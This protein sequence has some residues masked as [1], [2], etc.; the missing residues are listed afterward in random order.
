VRPIRLAFLGTPAAAV[1]AL[2]A[3]THVAEVVLVVTQPDRPRGRSNR[4]QPSPVKQ[5]ALQLGLKVAQPGRSAELD[6]ALQGVAPLDVGVL[7]AF[8]QL[9]RPEALSVPRRG[10]LNGHLSLLPRWRGAAP[11]QRA[12]LAG[13]VRT[14]VSVM[15]LEP[16]LDTGPVVSSW[17]TV[18]GADED[19]G[20]LTARLAVGAA[21]ML[22]EI[23]PQWTSGTVAAVPQPDSGITYAAKIE[24]RD[25]TIDWA[26]P[27][28]ECARRVRAMSPRPGAATSLGGAPFRVL[29]ATV[30]TG[31][32][33]PG[34]AERAGD[35]V[36]V[37]CGEG[38]LRLDLV[39]PAGRPVMAGSA[40]GRGVR[41]WP[42]VL[43][44]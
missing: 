13:D 39:Q 26:S 12:I 1:P 41:R 17:S 7:V 38:V 21:S 27:A 30:V 18:V 36:A 43:G 15:L 33:E 20:S 32:L 31:R 6:A 22:A 29:A 10:F 40:W 11:V 3:M 35:E 23:V 8:G 24:A 28:A 16:G 4:P 34:R 25:R 44:G 5:R 37:G 19:A 42:V 2:Q 14:G 9:V